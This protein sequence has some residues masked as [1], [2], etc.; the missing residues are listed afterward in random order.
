MDALGATRA[1]DARRSGSA[2]PCTTL[3]KRRGHARRSPRTV[4]TLEATERIARR[5][6][7]GAHPTTVGIEGAQDAR[8]A[9]PPKNSVRKINPQ[10]TPTPRPAPSPPDDVLREARLAYL[11]LMMVVRQVHQLPGHVHGPVVV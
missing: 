4:T 3:S 8:A 9:A 11:V 1:G 10:T 2:R 6:L 7:G 5:V